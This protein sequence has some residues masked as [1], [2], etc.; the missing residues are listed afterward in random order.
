MDG[1][2]NHDDFPLEMYVFGAA[3]LTIPRIVADRSS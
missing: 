3:V 2:N 1:G